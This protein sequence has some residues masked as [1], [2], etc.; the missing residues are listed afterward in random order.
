MW[1]MT[2]HVGVTKHVG[3]SNTIPINATSRPLGWPPVELVDEMVISY[4]D[5]RE[6]AAAVAD[7]YMRWTEALSGE[8]AQSFAAYCA[9]LDQEQ[10]AAGSYALAVANLQR[11]LWSVDAPPDS[12]ILDR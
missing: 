4:V 6:D 9:A 1:R 3:M 12:L 11:V 8:E 7:A 10:S 5:W 2:T